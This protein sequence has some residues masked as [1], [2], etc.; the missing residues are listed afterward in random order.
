ME[1]QFEVLAL[2]VL[3]ELP[4]LSWFRLQHKIFLDQ[5]LNLPLSGNFRDVLSDI[6]QGSIEFEFVIYQLRKNELHLRVKLS[7]LQTLQ[8]L[9]FELSDDIRVKGNHRLQE[10]KLTGVL[11]IERGF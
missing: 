4:C 5:S 6:N 9:L 7:D 2:K 11:L 3:V 10:P 1:T 8:V